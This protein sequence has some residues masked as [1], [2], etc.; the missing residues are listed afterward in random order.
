LRERLRRLLILFKNLVYEGD[1]RIHLPVP[2]LRLLSRLRQSASNRLAHHSPMHVQFLC[3][4][5]NRADA[6]FVLPADLLE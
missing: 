6:E 4:P 3:D 2:S 5:G 1:G